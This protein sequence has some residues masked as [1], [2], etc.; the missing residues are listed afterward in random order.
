MKRILIIFNLF[1]CITT[2]SFSIDVF[3]DK[4][5]YFQN[6]LNISQQQLVDLQTLFLEGNIEKEKI[7]KYRGRIKKL[8]EAFKMNT[9]FQKELK[10]ILGF[11]QYKIYQYRKAELISEQELIKMRDKIKFDSNQYHAVSKIV[12]E[13]NLKYETY[14][15][16]EGIK[17][18]T[19]KLFYLNKI[20]ITM[21]SKD[22]RIMQQLN[23]EQ[24]KQ[25]KLFVKEIRET[26]G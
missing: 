16:E 13:I 14:K 8:K 17:T 21:K 1:F 24:R 2:L 15:G 20:R 22:E 25:Y 5:E 23:D 12:N 4:V 18:L 19:Q 6:H 10:T 11:E 3:E 9:E 7:I 26:I